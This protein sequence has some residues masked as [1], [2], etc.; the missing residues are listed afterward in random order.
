MQVVIVLVATWIVGPAYKCAYQ[1]PTSEIKAE[2]N[3][4]CTIYTS[5]PSQGAQKVVGVLTVI[6]EYVIPLAFLVFFYVR[7][8][9]ALH[10]ID[11]SPPDGATVASVNTLRLSVVG[12]YND[13]VITPVYVV[14]PLILVDKRPVLCRVTQ[15]K[16][17]APK[18]CMIDALM[19][20]RRW[21]DYRLGGS[22]FIHRRLLMLLL[23][24]SVTEDMCEENQLNYR[25]EMMHM[26]A[27]VVS[28]ENSVQCWDVR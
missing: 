9:S 7:M 11:M 12:N 2:C 20:R 22:S 8:T 4:T 19:S 14:V 24:V 21:Q 17:A 25:S 13:C 15:R 27:L 5:W 28:C 16:Y 1:T 6:L 18:A 23:C 10:R 3:Y 26:V